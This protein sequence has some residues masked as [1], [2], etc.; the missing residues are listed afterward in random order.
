MKGPWYD[1]LYLRRLRIARL[2][3][4][5]IVIRRSFYKWHAKKARAR[6]ASRTG[7]K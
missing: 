2:Q 5:A 6:R 3:A 7:L 1:Y 4:T